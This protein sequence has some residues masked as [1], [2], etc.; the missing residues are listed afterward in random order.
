MVRASERALGAAAGLLVDRAAGEP[1][2]AVHPVARF[3]AAMDALER[4]WWRDSVPAG[5]RYALAGVVPA[6][7][8]GAAAE[9]LAG[10]VPATAVAVALSAASR[11]LLEVADRVAARLEDGDLAGARALLPALVGRDTEEL[12]EKEVARAAIESVAENLSD[13]VVA[14]ALWGAVAGAPGALAHRAAN[15]LD[16]MVGHRTARHHRFGRAAARLDDALGW[17]AARATAVLV[18]L[19]APGRIREVAWAV[20]HQAPSHPSPN[21]GVAEAAMAAA[22]GVSLGGTNWYRGRPEVRA[23][24]GRGPAPTAADL[25]AAVALGRRVVVL[26]AGALVGTALVAEAASRARGRR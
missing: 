1:P 21:A 24:V 19:A 20:R 12:D 14:S 7:A 5:A 22:L 10:P 25:R 8:L 23:P 15:T 3:G 16:A 13:A 17:P 6:A 9:G 18:A 11:E 26:A 4:R 2:A